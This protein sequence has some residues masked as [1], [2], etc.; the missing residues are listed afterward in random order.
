MAPLPRSGYGGAFVALLAELGYD[1]GDLS[2]EMFDALFALPSMRVQAFLE[3][4]L[5]SVTPRQSVVRQLG[6]SDYAL[7]TAILDGS[8]DEFLGQQHGLLT[9]DELAIQERTCQADVLREDES[10][11]A[12]LAQNAGLEHEIAQLEAQLQRANARNDKIATMVQRKM[13]Q[14][15]A[16]AREGFQSD[17]GGEN[18]HFSEVRGF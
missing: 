13:Q 11:D 1:R 6:E 16:H 18:Q 14:M 10:L 17:F 12:L 2:T 15:E 4:F 8:R 7:Y 9:G 3:W 5:A